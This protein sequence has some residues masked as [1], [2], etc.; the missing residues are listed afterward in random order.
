MRPPIL[1]VL[2]AAALG[3]AC[4]ASPLGGDG[5]SSGSSSL[6]DPPLTQFTT[7]TLPGPFGNVQAVLYNG[8]ELLIGTSV[9][10]TTTGFT[11]PAAPLTART[12]YTVVD[13]QCD[14]TVPT[15]PEP[16]TV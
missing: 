10:T 15:A 14:A 2:V 6:G 3:L 9:T 13:G 1:S 4:F 12:T 11:A 7:L 16:C 5:S 8:N